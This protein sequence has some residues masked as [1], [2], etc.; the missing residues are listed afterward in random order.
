[1]NAAPAAGADELATGATTLAGLLRNHRRIVALTGA[2]CSTPSGIPDYRDADGGWKH[3]RPVLYPDFVASPEVR[4]RYWARSSLGWPGFAAA[5]PN[6]AHHGLATLE[7]RGLLT[8]IVTQNVDRLHQQ[9]GSQA[10]VDLHGRLD[11][12]R[13]LGCDVRLARTDWQVELLRAN[14]AWSR[15]PAQAAPDGD[16]IPAATDFAEFRVPGC[17]DCGGIVKPDVVFYGEAVPAGVASAA[18]G[19]IEQA[20]ALV[21]VGSSLMVYSGFRLVRDAVAAGKP[22]V[23]INLGRTRADD[24]LTHHWRQ[25]CARALPALVARLAVQG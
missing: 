17:P 13:C 3:S 18:R 19:L 5:Q 1:M 11:Q 25:D 8:G 22:V 2:G 14:P 4:R 12:V 9:A 10:V 16:A 15:A 7:H 24:L 21:V 23:A 6:P 20:D